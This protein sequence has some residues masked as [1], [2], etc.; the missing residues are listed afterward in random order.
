MEEINELIRRY[1]LQEDHEHIIIPLPEKNGNRRRCF[2]LRRRFIRLAISEGHYIDYPLA[3]VIEAIVRYPEL[4][5]SE[6]LHLLYKEWDKEPPKFIE[7]EKDS[8]EQLP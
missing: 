3:E 8:T 6:A 1:G 2:L 7:D 4:L 5:V